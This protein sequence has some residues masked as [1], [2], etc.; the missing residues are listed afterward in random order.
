MVKV[1]VRPEWRENTRDCVNM[2]GKKEAHILGGKSDT[3]LHASCKRS[4]KME[5]KKERLK[6]ERE[7]ERPCLLSL[8]L[9]PF[10]CA[11]WCCCC[12]HVML[13]VITTHGWSHGLFSAPGWSRK[14][15][16]KGLTQQQKHKALLTLSRSLPP[17]CSALSPYISLL[18]RE[19]VSRI[20][21]R[22]RFLF[23]FFLVFFFLFLPRHFLLPRLW[24]VMGNHRVGVGGGGVP[25]PSSPHVLLLLLLF[26]V[27]C[28]FVV[29]LL[30]LH[31]MFCCCCCCF[32]SCFVLSCSFCFFTKC[33]VV[34]VV[35]FCRVF[36]CRAPFV[37]SQNVLLF[38]LLFFVVFFFVVLLLFLHKM[39]CCF[40]C[41]FLSCFFLFLHKMC[42]L[43]CRVRVT[44]D[45]VFLNIPR[46][47]WLNNPCLVLSCLA[48]PGIVLPCLA[49]SCLVLSWLVLPC[50]GLAW[51]VLPCLVLSYFVLSCLVSLRFAPCTHHSPTLC[52]RG[53]LEVQAASEG[54]V[55]LG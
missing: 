51:L 41:C 53:V 14:A 13:T 32:L 19:P 43:W 40:C 12:T 52:L 34:V 35:V 42:V 1:K 3:N 2:T 7:R 22:V 48:L 18:R 29:L 26:F 17:A 55:G 47:S 16:G 49:L 31:K 21:S 10:H 39:F 28:F 54:G 23:S 46:L 6:P 9:S 20:M 50:L 11:V 38:L 44:S 4:Q 45:A 27:V 5:E 24:L 15:W 37:S 25:R 36:F 33:F 30:F 8:S